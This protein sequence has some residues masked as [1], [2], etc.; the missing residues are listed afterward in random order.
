[1][2]QITCRNI[3]RTDSYL[4]AGAFVNEYTAD[5]LSEI[6]KKPIHQASIGN[7]VS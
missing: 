2:Q 5:R 1:M 4:E 3:E 6:Q 7:K